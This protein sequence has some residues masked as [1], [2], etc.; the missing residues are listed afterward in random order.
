MIEVSA[1]GIQFCFNASVGLLEKFTVTDEDRHISPLHRAPWVGTGEIMPED[2]VPHLKVLGGDFFC[3]PFGESEPAVP[4]HGW[5]AN[6]NWKIESV[7]NGELHAKLN[8]LVFGATVTKK[9]KVIDKHPFVYQKH[10]FSGGSGQFAV[11]NHANLSL[12]RG[13]LI[14]TS[15]KAMWET[16]KDPLESDSKRGRSVLIYPAQSKNPVTFPGQNGFVNLTRYPWGEGYEDF[17]IGIEAYGHEL[18]WTAVTR[19]DTGDL[20]LSVRNTKHLPMT[21]L[22]HS[23]GGRDY[24]P[25]S[26]RHK[27][28][29]GIEEGATASLLALTDK[30]NLSGP[31]HLTL[32]PKGTI[33]VRHAI[34]AINW[35]TSAAV[36]EIHIE[37][38]KM[39]IISETGATR[40]LDFDSEF[41]EL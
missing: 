27:G 29:L 34:G 39:I 31:G 2:A 21:M 3:A 24:A 38:E 1:R 4:L 8:R 22:W 14:R 30:Y 37:Q 36:A 10:A 26:S 7:K 41:L 13:G 28:C 15:A 40:K 33:D 6:S 19:P 16:P 25:W 23:N 12:P 11:S 18:G 20:F 5:P 32:D 9:L 17:V 35:P